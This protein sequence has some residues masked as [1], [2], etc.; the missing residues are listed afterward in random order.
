[1]EPKEDNL[2]T[3]IG[4]NL[5][6]WG[7]YLIDLCAELVKDYQID[8]FSFDGNYHPALCYCPACKLAYKTDRGRELPAKVNLDDIAYREYLVWRGDR[9]E[10][11]YLRFRRKIKA[12]NRDAV[13]M[14]W[15]VNAGRY[16]H[17]LYSPRTMPTR[18][19]RLFD[20]GMQE[21][22]LDETNFGG[23]VAPAFGEAYLRTVMSGRPCAAEPYMMSRGN[24][25]GSDS[26]PAHE[27]LTRTFLA[28]TSGNA[29]AVSLGWPG[30]L[31]SA[32]TALHEVER[33]ASG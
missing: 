9:L 21:W 2:G 33:R 6:P 27:L 23:S 5:G 19:N 16:G 25:Y 15:T 7:D 14:T 20:L 1:M 13:I 26:F 10:D 22:W 12:E 32:A 17:F 11:H 29:A 18:M 31:E 24:P 30:H 28:L 4:C 8:G 3:R